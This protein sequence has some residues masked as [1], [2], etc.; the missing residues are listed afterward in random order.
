MQPQLLFERPAQHLEH[1]PVVAVDSIR[2]AV[3]AIFH[4]QQLGVVLALLLLH[5]S[6]FLLLLLLRPLAAVLP[7]LLQPHWLRDAL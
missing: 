5:A 6:V 2:E 4:G 3:Q 1:R 7:P